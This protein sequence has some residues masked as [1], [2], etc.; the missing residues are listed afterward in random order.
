MYLFLS[1]L[2]SNRG[3]FDDIVPSWSMVQID[4]RMGAFGELLRDILIYS[5]NKKERSTLKN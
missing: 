3:L 2:L 4:Q 5:K 1:S